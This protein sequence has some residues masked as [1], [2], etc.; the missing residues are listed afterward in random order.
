MLQ[1]GIIHV[2]NRANQDE[3]I[4]NRTRDI[5]KHLWCCVRLANPPAFLWF[6]CSQPLAIWWRT[7]RENPMN[8][9]D[10]SCQPIAAQPNHP[11]L[12]KNE[13]TIAIAW[14]ALGGWL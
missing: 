3:D 11:L 9:S 12:K 7:S 1:I 14:E 2:P 10:N 13:T 8:P 6:E 5:S 4:G